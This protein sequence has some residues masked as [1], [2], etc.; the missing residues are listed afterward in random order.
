M[1]IP[2]KWYLTTA[3]PLNI[4]N[5]GGPVLKVCVVVSGV[6]VDQVPSFEN[7]LSRIA[8]I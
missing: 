3:Q 7:K 6:K 1:I 5:F 4:L 8:V 2:E